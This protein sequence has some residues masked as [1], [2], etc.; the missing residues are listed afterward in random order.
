MAEQTAE[1]FF[2]P[3]FRG[4]DR[5]DLT[6]ARTD[7]YAGRTTINSGTVAVTV[8]TALVNSDSLVDYGVQVSTVSPNVNSGGFVG[9]NSIV[10]GVSFA[11]SWATGVAV[12]QDVIVMWRLTRT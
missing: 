2:A 5:V 11:F 3:H 12:P 7:P 8:S 1:Q 9:V 6:P 4:P 10:S